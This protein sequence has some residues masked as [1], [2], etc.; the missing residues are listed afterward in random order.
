MDWTHRLR[1]RNLH[2]LL[3]LARTGNMSQSAQAMNTTQPA[4]SKWLKELEEDIGLPLFERHARGLKP[5]RHGDA[6]IAHARRIDAHLDSARDDMQVL[7]D[8]GS[9]LVVVGTSGA[10]ASDVVPLAVLHLL[11]QQP[12]SQ[13]RLSESTMN[14]LMPQLAAGELDVVVGRSAP[15]LHDAQIQAETLYLE[16]IHLVARPQHPLFKLDAPDWPDLMAYRWL[17]W[18]KGA[19]IRNALEN[20]LLAAGQA[21]PR[22]PIESNSVTLNL[23]LLNHS[24][25]IGLASHRAAL[26]F[27]QM[28]AMRILPVRLSG[29]GSV[30]MYWRSD[31]MNR[32]AVAGMLGALRHAAV[33]PA[34]D[35]GRV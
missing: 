30:S 14:V 31:S 33:T 28:G 32:S 27:T 17:I 4:L 15:E 5:T 10:S 25:M 11:Q 16:P 24:D 20:A 6:L 35:I 7:K 22:D 2:M 13:I 8:G 12:N 29:F 3:S 26:R 34:A 1:L 18:P 19:P 21:L 23:T 9:G